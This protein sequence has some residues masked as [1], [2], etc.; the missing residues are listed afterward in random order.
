MWG[1]PRNYLLR[2]QM[3][4]PDVM[5]SRV[6]RSLG[7]LGCVGLDEGDS[8][9]FKYRAATCCPKI[10]SL[11]SGYGPHMR[12]RANTRV[13]CV[14]VGMYVH[15]CRRACIHACARM[16]IY[17]YSLRCSVV[18]GVRCKVVSFVSAVQKCVL[19]KTKKMFQ[20]DSKN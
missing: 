20:S 17:I 15:A 6:A 4:A 1:L 5:A 3:R 2:H 16:H 19:K 7:R 18:P 8:Q 10:L 11:F 12:A 14:Y 9:K 13:E